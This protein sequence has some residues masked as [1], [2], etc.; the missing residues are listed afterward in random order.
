MSQQTPPESRLQGINCIDGIGPVKLRDVL[1]EL[2]VALGR[3]ASVL[4]P[5]DD[6]REDLLACEQEGV[7]AVHHTALS[8]AVVSVVASERVRKVTRKHL[9]PLQLRH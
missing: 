1:G 7:D 2:E 6:A 9:S 8:F 4:W 5:L 3:L